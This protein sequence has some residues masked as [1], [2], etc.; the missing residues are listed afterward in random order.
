[1]AEGYNKQVIFDI[2]SKFAHIVSREINVNKVI[3]YGSYSK[4]NPNNDS[5]IDVAV[6]SPDFTGD[7]L[8]DQFRLMKFRR[9][10]DLRIEPMPFR[11]EEFIPE[12]PFVKEIIETGVV[13]FS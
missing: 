12:D 7:R 13:I 11:P 1:M 6:I 5:D 8:E 2:V 4:G 3:L 10:I 9:K